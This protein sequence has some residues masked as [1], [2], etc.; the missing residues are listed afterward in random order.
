MR[1]KEEKVRVLSE[2]RKGGVRI[3]IQTESIYTVSQV[4][5]EGIIW[6]LVISNNNI[7]ILKTVLHSMLFVK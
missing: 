2:E 4:N 3:L 7:V 5:L 6:W 1:E